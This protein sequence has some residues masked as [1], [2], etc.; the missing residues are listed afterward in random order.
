MSELQRPDGAT[1]H[2]EE[3]GAD[4]PTIVMATYFGWVPGVFDA[5]L[6][7]LEPD[8]RIVSYHLRGTGESSR[9]GPFDRDTDAGD[10]EAVLEAAGGDAVLLSLA[11][12][13]NRAARVAVRRPDLVA[14]LA[15]IGAPPLSRSA[16]AGSDAMLASEGTVQA[17]Q[18]MVESNYR[19]AVRNMVEGSNPQLDEEGIRER[20]DRQVEFCS[21]EAMLGRIRAWTDESPEDDARALGDRLWVLAASAAGGPWY[22]RREEVIRITEEL[23]PEARIEVVEPGLESNPERAVEV[24]RKITAPLQAG[25][26]AQGRG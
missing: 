18:A 26:V 24:L 12:S 17:F 21:G 15:A 16:Y 2:Y 8:H 1:I 10:L 9:Q 13:N 4:G 14:A 5:T 25:G 23:M 6:D 3:R 7:L 19:A 22:P 11:D 20:V